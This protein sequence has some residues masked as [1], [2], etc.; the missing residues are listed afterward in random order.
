MWTLFQVNKLRCIMPT[1]WNSETIM[2]I[3]KSDFHFH[4]HSIS[5]PQ[6][7]FYFWTNHNSIPWPLETVRSVRGPLC[8]F[9]HS[10]FET[11][12]AQNGPNPPQD[13]YLALATCTLASFVQLTRGSF[14]RLTLIVFHNLLKE[15]PLT[16]S[17]QVST[18]T[19][20]CWCQAAPEPWMA[21]I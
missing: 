12:N 10:S 14:L 16:F 15:R 4:K 1:L 8:F 2:E 3:L 7:Q 17:R 9:L 11:S 21:S 5:V 18:F 13:V 6:R 19:G 20:V